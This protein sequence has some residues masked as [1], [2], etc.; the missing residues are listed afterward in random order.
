M[1]ENVAAE[2]DLQLLRGWIGR[3]ER[4]SDVITPE[5]VRRFNATL[6][7]DVDTLKVGEPA[8]LLIHLCLAPTVAATAIL[9]PGRSSTARRF[10]AAG[11][12]PAA[13]VGG[14]RVDVQQQS[15]GW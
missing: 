5:L 8:P 7:L 1:P 12:A 2:P 3:E 15:S 9:G 11:A 14:R 4:V 13:H 10:C 6:N